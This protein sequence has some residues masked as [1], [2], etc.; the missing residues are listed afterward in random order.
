MGPRR[1]V[2]THVGTAGGVVIGVGVGHP[3]TQAIAVQAYRIHMVPLMQP[4]ANVKN[5]VHN[6]EFHGLCICLL[7]R[8]LITV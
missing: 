4:Y 6:F 5:E 3:S 8:A 1:Q 7:S 2:D